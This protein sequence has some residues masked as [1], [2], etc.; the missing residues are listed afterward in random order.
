MPSGCMPKNPM[1]TEPFAAHLF[2]ATNAAK[3]DSRRYVSDMPNDQP[4]AAAPMP[5]TSETATFAAA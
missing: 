1:G 3:L 2:T 4:N 5:A